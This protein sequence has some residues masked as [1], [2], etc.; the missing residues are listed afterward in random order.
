MQSH[1]ME[2]EGERKSRAA[3]RSKIT[4]LQLANDNRHSHINTIKIKGDP[5]SDHTACL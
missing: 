1:M 3:G 4:T 2:R 5:S